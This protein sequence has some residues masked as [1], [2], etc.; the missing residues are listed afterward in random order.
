MRDPKKD[1]REGDE[2]RREGDELRREGTV[3]LVDQVKPDAVYYRVTDDQGG[4]V[5]A[6][7]LSLE[8]W[9]AAWEGE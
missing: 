1:P 8:D 4:L 9:R 5:G 7:W 6:W 3:I 2:L